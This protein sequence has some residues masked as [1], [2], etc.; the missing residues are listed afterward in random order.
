MRNFRI[1]FHH[2]LRVLAIAPPTYFAAAVFLFLTG[3]L[4][5]YALWQS[6]Q[7]P[8]ADTPVVNLFRIFPLP[9]LFIVPLL[10]MRCF[11]DEYRSGTLSA[12][13]STPARPSQ[14]VFAKFS[15]AYVFYLLLWALALLFPLVAWWQLD[16]GMQDPRLLP[17]DALFGGYLF[18]AAGGAFYLAVGVFAS[19][20]TRSVLVAALLTAAALFLLVLLGPVMSQVPF[21]NYTW[22]DALQKPAEYLD[23][24]KHLHSYL[25]GIGD[26]RPLFFF[27]TGAVLSL[28]L[29]TLA[30]EAKA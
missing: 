7:A 24:Y 15:A 10:T 4:Y 14:V 28:G 19:S 8:S 30:V 20:V 26:T 23:T 1:L 11:A 27:G 5:L 25:R 3:G 2:E 12:L 29:A 13:L 22:T 16:N 18:M 17:V 9:L 21:G 6:A